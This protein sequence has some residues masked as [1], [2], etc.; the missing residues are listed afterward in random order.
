MKR[1]C[2]I[3]DL[4]NDPQLIKEYEDYH[5]KVWPEIIKSIRDAGIEQ[6][7]IYR[8]ETR[9]FMIM[10][11]N[12]EFS[13]EKKQQAD[14][15]NPKVQEWEELMWKYQQ[16]IAGAAKGEKWILMEKIFGLNE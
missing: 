2:L 12:D 3:L 9:L 4:K 1:Y 5:K 14:R 13:F 10:E 16:P 8:R 7:E 11:V 6:M 15:D